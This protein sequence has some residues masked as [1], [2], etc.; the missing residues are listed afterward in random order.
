MNR[1]GSWIWPL[2]YLYFTFYKKCYQRYI[3]WCR[4]LQQH[5]KSKD[6][7]DNVSLYLYDF[8]GFLQGRSRI[9]FIQTDPGPKTDK[10]NH[11]RR[12]SLNI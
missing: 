10:S 8:A 6:V 4:I 5:K 1:K 7:C 12:A 3:R 11:K 2:P 9:R